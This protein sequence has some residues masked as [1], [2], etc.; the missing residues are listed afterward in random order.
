MLVALFVAL[1]VPMTSIAQVQ[2]EAVDSLLV[3]EQFDVNTNGDELTAPVNVG[4]RSYRFVLD[5]G[6]YLTAVDSAFR[7]ELGEVKDLVLADTPN[8]CQA[9]ALF[10][11]PDAFVGRL[12]LK[13]IETIGCMR[14]VKI[15]D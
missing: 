2:R 13:G 1:Q 9:I 12:S 4:G 14:V 11:P 7:A 8:G 15:I 10:D 5:S 6:S 3:L